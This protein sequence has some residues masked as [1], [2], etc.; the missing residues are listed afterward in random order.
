MNKLI[1]AEKPS[2]AKIL[3][4]VVGARE[5]IYSKS[6]KAFCYFGNNY[7]VVNARGHLYGLGEP[8]DYGY[9]KAYKLEEL[10]MFPDFKIFPCG[11]DTEE[12]RS[13][14][15]ELMNKDDI[16]EIICATDAGREG[17]LIF[18]HIYEAN[19]CTKPVKR[20]WCNSMTDEAIREQLKN[21]PPDSDYDGEY[22]SALA[23][24][25]SDWIIGMNLSRLY[26]VLDN[27][28]HHIG[29]VK[30]P[31]LSII[32]ERDNEIQNF[33]KSVSYRLEMPD[34]ALS[35][36]AFDTRD[37]A[38]RQMR[39]ANG[40]E[41]SVIS[42]KSEEKSKNRPL[43]H[44]LTSLQQEANEQYGYT[45]KE[46]LDAAQSLYEKRLLTY[47]RTDCNYISEDMKH[48]VIRIVD[49]IAAIPEYAERADR[50]TTQGLNLDERVVNNSRMNGHEHHAI[51]PE[52]FTGKADALSEIEKNIYGLVVNRLLCAVDK[53][54]KYT[55]T[56]YIF[57]CNNI[58][59]KLK[60]ETPVQIGW[61]EYD[62]EYKKE[63]TSAHK[64]TEGNKFTAE[65]IK[66]KEIEAQPPK[67]YTDATLLSVMSNIDNRIEDKELKS[68]V[69]GKGIGTEAT[70]A[71]VIEDLI[72][73]GYAE[74]NHRN[75][76]S[77]QFGRD[78][79]ASVP[80]SVKSVERTAEWEQIFT[81]IK[82]KGIS[83]EPFI[84]DVKDYVR[85][86]IELEKSPDRNRT[87][88]HSDNPNSPK[89]EP[90]G[91]CPRC[92]KNIYEG[93]KNYYCESGNDGC[94][95][96]LW[97]E[98]KFL[99]SSVTP[100]KAVKLLNGDPV[101]MKAVSRDGEEY[102][103]EYVLEDTG[104][105]INLKRISQEKKKVG[106]CPLCGKNVLEGKSNFYCES[107]KDGCEFTLWKEDRYNGIT[108][109]SSNAF[110]LLS[111][112]KIYRVRKQLNGEGE[113]KAYVMV[114]NGKYAN[115]RA[116]EE[117]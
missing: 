63:S 11:E 97:K 116:S 86:V 61:K 9:S 105:Y 26:G 44:N 94:G 10:P 43:L 69:S 103:A 50:L 96:T 64:Y 37:E 30:T 19:H 67:H 87:P 7:Y 41:I 111:G 115:I 33:K 108:I 47:P 42:A 31:V 106:T 56:N 100:E 91:I 71:E 39:S 74:R 24:Q 57:D 15:S 29:R 110:D 3:A 79:I 92:G 8:E 80:D 99:K 35:E 88:V 89:R 104:K 45:A 93:K 13:L 28:A 112:K 68:A 18:R 59:Y 27:Y 49:R 60:T 101:K 2:T 25:K 4:H 77:T 20:L 117:K 95:F 48:S 82:E 70:R 98:D 36:T 53:P 17:E 1:L 90:V 16:E 109:T 6:G 75:I 40:K 5:K 22:Y 114:I 12:L 72:R 14:I 102:E 65:G 76:V 51:I 83:A 23:R 85:S 32:V 62:R 38:E 21:L 66:V 107:G 52:A 78:F 73:A 113:K 81:N 46:T 34:G 54:Y 58:T 84:R 55:E